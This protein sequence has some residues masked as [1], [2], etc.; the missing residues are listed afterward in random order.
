MTVMLP[1][2]QGLIVLFILSLSFNLLL[3]PKIALLQMLFIKSLFGG[4]DSHN[5][6]S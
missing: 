3:K 5:S 1:V 2:P 6:L 4:V